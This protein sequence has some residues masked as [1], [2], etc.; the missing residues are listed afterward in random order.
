MFTGNLNLIAP[1]E[2]QNSVY[3]SKA[4]CLSSQNS[5]ASFY[6]LPSPSWLKECPNILPCSSRNL[7]IS[8]YPSSPSIIHSVLLIL[9]PE[10]FS[11][12][13]VLLYLHC[14]PYS[15]VPVPHYLS[16]VPMDHLATH[17]PN[18]TLSTLRR[19]T[20]FLIFQLCLSFSPPRPPTPILLN[21]VLHVFVAE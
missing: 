1:W 12:L 20:V 18:Q 3:T 9:S 14:L 16:P 5:P 19:E 15:L 11:N 13:P 21:T 10:C 17:T 6:N 2:P 4:N 7:G 8:P